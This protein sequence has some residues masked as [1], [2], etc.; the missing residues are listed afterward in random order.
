MKMVDTKDAAHKAMLRHSNLY[1]P[2]VRCCYAE[3]NGCTAWANVQ[4]GF[5]T[6]CALCSKGR[7]QM[8][9]WKRQQTMQSRILEMQSQ[10]QWLF[11][12]HEASVKVDTAKAR[13]VDAGKDAEAL[14]MA[15]KQERA[16]A[17]D[18]EEGFFYVS[19]GS[20]AEA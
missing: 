18:H 17:E 13:N 20:S 19:Q 9:C 11:R 15:V 16:I 7:H 1:V 14:P 4:G 5:E 12:Q 10:I 2:L 3:T 6:C 8:D